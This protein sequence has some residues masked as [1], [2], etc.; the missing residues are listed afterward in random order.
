MRVGKILRIIVSYVN[1]IVFLNSLTLYRY[2]IK[3]RLCYS[4]IVIRERKK[5]EGQTDGRMSRRRQ[6]CLCYLIFVNLLLNRVTWQ[7]GIFKW[8]ITT[9]QLVCGLFYWL[10]I[11]IGG[12][13]TLCT[14]ISGQVELRRRHAKQSSRKHFFMISSSVPASRFLLLLP[15][16]MVIQGHDVYHS[17]NPN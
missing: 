13:I 10:M 2:R 4:L 16:T 8:G 5:T 9:I 17:K 6:W 14:F 12:S 3:R 1:K 11:D 7:L 15:S